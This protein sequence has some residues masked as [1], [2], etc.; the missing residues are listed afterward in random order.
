MS[1]SD[2]LGLYYR[3]SSESYAIPSGDSRERFP[4]HSYSHPERSH[5]VFRKYAKRDY[6]R[7]SETSK[8]CRDFK[9]HQ[10]AM[11]RIDRTLSLGD[12]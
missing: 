11:I 12:A 4:L 9:S 8:K 7:D 1:S 2:E 10:I 6:R 5:R 3:A